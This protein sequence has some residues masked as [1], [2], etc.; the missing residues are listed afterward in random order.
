MFPASAQCLR[1]LCAES[2]QYFA[3]I[4]K[5]LG[6]AL[7]NTSEWSANLFNLLDLLFLHKNQNK[8]PFKKKM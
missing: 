3:L 1:N 8:K 2:H 6:E 7:D 4:V 5:V